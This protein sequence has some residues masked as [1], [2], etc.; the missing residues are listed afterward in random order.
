[1]CIARRGER[2]VREEQRGIVI[3]GAQPTLP[4]GLRMTLGSGLL[5]RLL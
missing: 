3:W 5:D 4:W 2:W 1:M